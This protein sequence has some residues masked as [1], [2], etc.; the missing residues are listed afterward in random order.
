MPKRFFKRKIYD[1]LLEWKDWSKGRYAILIEGARRIG[2][3][4][5][6]EEFAKNEYEQYIKIDFSEAG[7]EIHGLFNDM[8]DL[9]RFFL[10]LQTYSGKS[11]I[12]RKSVI[13]FDE[14]QFCPKA[15]QAIK[16]LVADGRYDYIETG[17]LIS[18]KK[19]V[20][21]ILIPS[22][23]EQIDMYPMD[24]EEFLWAIGEKQKFD[25]IRSAYEN[26]QPTG[27][28][29]NRHLMSEFRLYMLV[30]GMP[31]A[32]NAYLDYNDFAEV[33]KV[34]RKILK[35]YDAD[36][37]K[38]D[39]KGRASI[40]FNSVPAELSRNTMRYKI[41]S[42]IDG[43]RFDRLGEVFAD[44]VDSK[45]VNVAY[46]ADDPGIGLALH[47]NHDYFKMFV[48]DTG[49]FI[50]MVFLDKDYTENIIY[51]KLLADKLPADLGYVY[52]N[53]VAQLMCTAGHSLYYYTFRQQDG[54]EKPKFYEI[55]FLI[56]KGDKICPIEVKSSTNKSHKSL[57][58]FQEK[59]SSRIKQRYLLYTKDIRKE[60]DILCLPVYM[61]GLL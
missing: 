16:H 2:K 20:K 25:F 57:D 51:K 6:T 5:I 48:A 43:G 9:D 24:F 49:L 34:K 61:A 41:G 39:P 36:F 14:V 11:L 13:I 12:E 46:H 60:Q 31:Q 33:D 3:S 40:I 18:I 17:S 27:D 28:S 47:A 45:T 15:R 19:N 44:I 4:T 38:I 22:E 58:R 26:M 53:V 23:E 21:D 29:M 56:S 37:R 52:E 35:L 8:R 30:G 54:T 42:V 7:S 1:R 55:D 32:V 10:M 59:Y 50:T